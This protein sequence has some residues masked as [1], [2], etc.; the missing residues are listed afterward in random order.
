MAEKEETK[1]SEVPQ[2]EEHAAK[3]KDQP[4]GGAVRLQAK[5]SLINGMKTIFHVSPVTKFLINE[6]S[7]ILSN[8]TILFLFSI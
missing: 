7:F 1:Y 6:H 4:E 2:N 8:K 5:M 3:D